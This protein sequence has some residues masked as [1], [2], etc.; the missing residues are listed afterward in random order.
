VRLKGREDLRNVTEN[1]RESPKVNMECTVV[2][3][4]VIDP[5]FFEEP[6]GDW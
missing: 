4:K 1:E 6:T 5:F 2:K 3:N